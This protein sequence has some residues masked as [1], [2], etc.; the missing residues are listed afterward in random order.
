MSL[1]E[2]IVQIPTTSPDVYAFRIRGK[3]TAEDMH[4]MAETMN[5][6]FDSGRT[7][8]MLLHF[9]AF[10]GT[11]AGAM[12]DVENLKSRFRSLAHVD[13]YAVIGAPKIAAAMV[14]LMDK[15]I[16]VDARSFDQA[17]ATDA[18]AFVGA[19]PLS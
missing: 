13:K 3:V 15:V 19:R 7:V 11:E 14:D 5:A 10:D 16:P 4:A 2:T 1:N 6:V 17:E 12:F 9:D 8:S 18:W